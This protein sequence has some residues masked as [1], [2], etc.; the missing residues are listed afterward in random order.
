MFPRALVAT[1]TV[2]AVVL[3]DVRADDRAPPASPERSPSV[4][5]AHDVRPI[6]SNNCFQCHGP[7][8]NDRA[9]G[10]RLD[11][12]E[13]AKRR[14]KSGVTAIVPG[15]PGAS[16]ILR[17]VAHPS[18]D[19]RMP[20]PET[21]K[22]LSTREIEILREWILAGAPWEGHWAFTPPR[23]PPLPA[24][25]VRDWPRGPID[26][27]VLAR[28]EERGLRPS[29]EA[30]RYTLIRR[31][32]LDLTGILPSPERAAR[33][34]SDNAPDAY[35]RLVDELL[36]SAHYG[37]RWG[38]HWL[39]QARYADSNGYSHDSPRRAWP[40]RDWV[41]AAVN[42]DLPFDEF[43]IEQLAGDLLPD[44]SVEQLVATGF[45]RNT[46][47]STEG[48]SDPEQF[49][50][51]SVIDRVNTTGAV[52]LGLTLGC[53]QCHSHKF[54]PIAQR[55]YYELFAFFNN[56]EDRNHARPEIQVPL[57]G[58]RERREAIAV[59]KASLATLGET[60][61]PGTADEERARLTKAIGK[62]EA[63]A[64]KLRVGA[65]V[66][67]ERNEL[68]PTHRFVRG[69]F[70]R[71]AEQVEPGVPKALGA[72][73]PA[74]S[75]PTRLDLARWLVSRE[76]PLTARVMVNRVWM[77]FFGRGI[78]ETENDFGTQGTLPTHPDLLDWL[79][80]EW[81]ERGWSMK[82]LHRWIVTSA[83]YRQSSRA[84][85]ELDAVDRRGIWLG[86]QQRLRVDA[87]V[88]RDIALSASGLLHR[89]MG[90]APIYPPQPDG[91]YAFTQVKH[92]WPTTRGQDRFRRGLYIQYFRNTPY[93]LLSTFDAPNFSQTCT[94]RFRSN[95]PL[96]SLTL[97][98]DEALFEI[99]RALA[100]RVSESSSDRIEDRLEFLF[101]RVVVRPPTGDELSVLARF[102]ALQVERFRADPK[103]AEAAA[104]AALAEAL[105]AAEAAAWVAVARVLLNL[106]EAITRE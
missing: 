51:E 73:T 22:R 55:E 13:D 83:T 71:P 106:D 15:D 50:V 66:M 6:L 48:G 78:V 33:F 65:M 30:D 80:V 7:D 77:H 91:V 82:E 87:E 37:E 4:R 92:P 101:R 79:A 26:T 60:A 74:D 5:F 100:A 98:N 58:Y 31:V 40:Y 38:K 75:R 42:A 86:R 49:R 57:P 96:Q 99:A 1:A 81:V 36:A 19:E 95:T 88:V 20:P 68:R 14:L 44:P 43:T 64:K 18:A 72:L 16:A 47:I 45:H 52:W 8:E 89:A 56:T 25:R 70:L 24:I 53:A 3:V 85:P 84:R 10:L 9:A 29:P 34:A 90:G 63:E 12:E 97:A 93:P 39:D 67:R 59:A 28:L 62:L 41:I 104:S 32:S 27:F 105:G 11:V 21:Q 23:R 76:N 61:T 69:D 35:E 46:L 54:D 94:R 102:Y 2:C 17:R 103:G